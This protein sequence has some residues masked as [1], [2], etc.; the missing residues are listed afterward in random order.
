MDI[1]YKKIL[2]GIVLGIF[3]TTLLWTGSAAI[4][5]KRRY[6]AAAESLAQYMGQLELARQRNAEYAAIYSAARTTNKELGNSLSRCTGSLSE[7]RS[8]LREV[9]RRYIE[10]ENLLNSARFYD[11]DTDSYDSSSD[12]NIGE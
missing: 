9:E 12:S 6:T 11:S 8:Q 1:K 3:L 2:H 5:N 10:M 7:L 4:Y